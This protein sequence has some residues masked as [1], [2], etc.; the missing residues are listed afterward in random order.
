MDQAADATST[1]IARLRYRGAPPAPIA[2]PLRA[3]FRYIGNQGGNSGE[4]GQGR[5]GNGPWPWGRAP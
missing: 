2:P 3:A 1:V 5:Q 4:C